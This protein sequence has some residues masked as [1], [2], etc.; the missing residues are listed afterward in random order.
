MGPAKESLG[1]TG[2][3]RFGVGLGKARDLE[4]PEAIRAPI[5]HI[6]AGC[7]MRVPLPANRPPSNGSVGR[8][9]S[10]SGVGGWGGLWAGGQGPCP[11]CWRVGLV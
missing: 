9:P 10:L 4:V 5:L 11:A 3:G 8:R 6:N 1:R 7:A 2:G